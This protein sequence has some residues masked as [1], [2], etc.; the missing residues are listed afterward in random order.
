MRIAVAT[1][2]FAMSYAPAASAA[3]IGIFGA[4]DCSTCDISIAA[5]E[6]QTIFI[7]VANA[8]N[9]VIGASLRVEGLPSGWTAVAVPP[10][11]SGHAG[12][13]FGPNG[14][15]VGFSFPQLSNC[16]RLYTVQLH[17]AT[18]VQD[19]ALRVVAA[20]PPLVPPNCPSVVPCPNDPCG[21]DP[22]QCVT[23]GTLLINSSVGCTVG[24][25]DIPW[26]LVKSLFQ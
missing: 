6:T 20:Q 11:G 19:V 26:G 4:E 10:V 14:A 21:D 18:T 24:T 9:G 17:A 1:L 16:V 3:S 15:V 5:G 13:P 12:D 23:G 25:T 8:P 7:S 22:P 2:I